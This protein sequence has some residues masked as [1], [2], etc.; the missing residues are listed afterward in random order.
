MKE[1]LFGELER[2]ELLLLI[3]L[4]LSE[5]L[6]AAVHR[7]AVDDVNDVLSDLEVG[8]RF[9]RPARLDLSDSAPLAAPTEDFVMGDD[10]RTGR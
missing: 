6:Q 1:G 8:P 10:D 4:T 2:K 7:N 5:A 3:G 9:E